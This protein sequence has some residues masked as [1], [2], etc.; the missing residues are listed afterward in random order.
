MQHV[1]MWSSDTQDFYLHSKKKVPTVLD[2]ASFTG[3]FESVFI[4]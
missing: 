1:M 3:A 2:A 4:W